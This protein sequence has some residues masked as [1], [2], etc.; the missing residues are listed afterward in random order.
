MIH[1]YWLFLHLIRPT[2]GKPL[3]TVT[4]LNNEVTMVAISPGDHS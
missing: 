1:K 2:K 3:V 4:D